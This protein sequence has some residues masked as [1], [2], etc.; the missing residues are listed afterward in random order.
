[1][2]KQDILSG[3]QFRFNS[4]S[5]ST[6]YLTTKNTIHEVF[7]TE[8]GEEVMDDWHCNVDF[9]GTK[10]MKVYSLFCGRLYYRTIPFKDLIPY[11]N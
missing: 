3:K 11:E 10:L 1:M 9:I 4:G 8:N 6:F 5:T 2:T 7:R